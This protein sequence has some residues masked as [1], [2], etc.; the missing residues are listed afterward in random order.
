[1]LKKLQLI[2]CILLLTSP[3][4]GATQQVLFSCNPSNPL[5]NTATEYQGI[6]T[7]GQGSHANWT[8]DETSQKA[9]FPTDGAIGDQ[10]ILLT[11]AP[12]G[13]NTYKLTVRVNEAEPGTPT[14][15]T[16]SNP[17]STCQD[18]VND[19][20]ITQGDFAS[21]E[22]VPSSTPTTRTA[23]CSYT[24]TPTVSNETVMM[25]GGGTNTLGADNNTRYLSL[26]GYMAA[27]SNEVDASFL[28]STGGE[29]KKF[30]MWIETV[31]GGTATQTFTYRDSASSDSIVITYTAAQ[32]GVKCNNVDTYGSASAGNRFVI[33]RTATNTPDAT[34]FKT[35]IVFV[36]TTTG[37]WIIPITSQD[38]LSLTTTEYINISGS[39]AIWTSDELVRD[40][41]IQTGS[42]ASDMIIKNIYVEHKLDPGATGDIFTYRLRAN[43]GDATAE[44][45]AICDGVTTCNASATVTISDDDL[46][47]T[48]VI[49]TDGGTLAADSVM[50]SY[51]AFIAPPSVGRTRR[52]SVTKL[53]TFDVE[54][55]LDGMPDIITIN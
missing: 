55:Y 47:A 6:G 36:P 19:T 7:V 31:P 8:T 37:E 4:Y 22:S 16:V 50:I 52:V 43:A 20:A 53:E 29:Y 44:L 5:D 12:G 11:G 30:C 51:T 17:D 35:A 13:G 26:A 41:T 48:R 42:F 24:F 21:V 54:E 10:R 9:L 33:V 34:R 28:A 32:N 2:C 25:G 27:D 40:Q 18:L 49:P 45:E 14:V 46:M 1:M 38:T 23:Q 3:V 39:S 15:C